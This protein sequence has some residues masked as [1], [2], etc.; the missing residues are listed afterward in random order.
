LIKSQVFQERLRNGLAN[1]QTSI[2]PGS[3]VIG[4]VVLARLSGGLQSLEWMAFDKY[5]RH[6][7]AEAMDQQVLVI[8]VNEADLAQLKTYPVPDAELAKLIQTIQTHQPAA[9]GVDIF[10]DQPVPPGSQ[11]LMQ[12][13]KQQSNVIGIERL[14]LSPQEASV[15]PSP[16]LPNDQVG[17]ANAVLDADGAVRLSLLWAEDDRGETKDSFSSILANIYLETQGIQSSPGIRDSQSVRLGNVEIPRFQGN[18]G[19]YA[20]GQSGGLATLINYRS[21]RQPFRV[22]SLAD[23]KA[24]RFQPEWIKGKVVLVGMTAASS[25]DYVTVHAIDSANPALIDGVMV[26]AHAIS[27][28]INAAQVG[29]PLIQTWPDDGE[30][31]W[32]IAWGGLGIVLGWV[33]RS[34]LKLVVL[35]LGSGI[36]LLGMSYGLLLLGWWIP[37]MPPLLVFLMNGAGLTAFYRHDQALRSRIRERQLVINETFDAIHN[38]PLQTLSRLLSQSRDESLTRSDTRM[39][40]QELDREVRGIYESMQQAVGAGDEMLYVSQDLRVNLREPMPEVLRQ[41]YEDVLARNWPH[42]QNVKLKLVDFQ[43]IDERFLDL[44]MRRDLCRFLE[45]AITNVG[46]HGVGVTRL[47]VRCAVKDGVNV[48]R[49]ADNGAGKLSER[50]GMGTQQAKRLA[51]RLRGEF[52]RLKSEPQGMVCQLSWKPQRRWLG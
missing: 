51:K 31:L 20:Q 24:N 29:R 7:P 21:G 39:G 1:W 50:E 15:K 38:G 5:L 35:L 14:A 27:Q 25:K 47:E 6:R 11:Q 33:V 28:L 9:I 18:T 40:L 52:G 3:I 41:V 2:L 34:P 32:I 42:L 45:E 19:G 8:G 36:G 23:I 16:G 49:V 30:Y 43:P 17:F 13:F 4:L 48:V 22:L 46:K 44:G 10:R 37:V 26:Q 12:V